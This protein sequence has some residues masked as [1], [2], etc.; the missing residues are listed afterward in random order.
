M[1]VPYGETE[2]GFERHLGTN[3]LGHFLLFQLL[4]PALL[5]SSSPSF[6]SRVVAVSSSA[7]HNV[8]IHFDDYTLRSRPEGYDKW[9]G[10]GQSKLANIYFSNELERR[11]GSKGIHSTSVMPGGIET[12][13]QRHLE[14]D[15]IAN[16]RKH[17][18]N[19]LG[20]KNTAQGAA[21]QVWAA[22]GKEWESS[23]GK[24]LE[25]MAVAPLGGKGT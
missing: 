24:Y 2:D 8:P 20:M 25:D 1:A 10:Y 18:K 11:Y 9:A 22:V 3:H 17:E 16:A 7:H 4:K 5:S 15:F 19:R 21:T 23:G 13:L 14:P 12:P 6:P